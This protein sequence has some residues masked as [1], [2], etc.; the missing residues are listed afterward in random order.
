MTGAVRGSWL[1]LATVLVTMA[2]P[3]RAAGCEQSQAVYTERQNGYELRFHA[4]ERWEASANT[5]AIVELAFPDRE[6]T[7][8]GP[9]WLP[10]GTSHDRI[11]LYHG[12]ELPGIEEDEPGSGEAELNA[13][14]VW[15]G[16]VLALADNDIAELPWFDAAPPAQTLLLPNLG[17][18]I[19][20]SGLV[21]GPGDEPHDVFTL[22]GCAE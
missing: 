11:R 10:N 22:A 2:L 20:Y 14:L 8:W 5:V 4:P 13:C 21:L 7:V 3:A 18:T 17:P 19:R 12:C 16:V 15:E 9:I 1:A 6:T